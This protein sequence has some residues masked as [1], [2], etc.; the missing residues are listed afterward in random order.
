MD[1]SLWGREWLGSQTEV[2]TLDVK[3]A[4]LTAQSILHDYQD[5]FKGLGHIGTSSFVVDPSATPVQHTSRCIP[6]ALKKEVKAKL[7]D[8]ERRGI[9]VKETAP[10]EWISNM[11]VVAKPKKIRICLD[12]QELN[13]V[14][15][16]LKYQM[17]TL[18]ELLPKLCKAKIFSTP[19]AKDSFYQISLDEPSSKLTALWTPFGRYRYLQM[20]FSVSLTPEEFE[21]NLQEKLADLEGVEVIQDDIIVMGFG[22][23]QE[24]AVLNHDENLIKLLERARKVNLR[25]NSLKM[26][27]RKPEVKFMQHVISK[28]GLKPDPAKVK[29]VEDMPQ[30]SC[31]QE[32]LSLLGFVN[33]LSRFLLRLADVAQPLRD[34]TCKDAKFTW[35]KQHDTAFKEVKKLVV[36][37]PILKYY[38]CNAEV[39]LQ[40]DASERGLGAVILQ[41]G[42]LVAFAS[43]TLSP[44]ERRYA[45]IEKECLPIV[46]ACQR[47][48]QYISR[49]EKIKVESDHKPLQAIFKKSV[50]ASHPMQIAKDVTPPTSVQ[51]GCYIQTRF[52][53]VHSRPSFKSLPRQPRKGRQRVS[54]VCNE[55]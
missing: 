15:Q 40:W 6:I 23:T 36:N 14:I 31:K 33:Y 55:S 47:F 41:N 2:L 7:E 35:A 18:D 1:R 51:S 42:Q 30:P 48:S 54:S 38:D 26:E 22:E 3:Q 46:F 29:A 17:P 53:D 25:L 13:K 52:A 4:P 27:Q 50:L 10:T 20:P 21:S 9:I 43:E 24:Q 49:Q 19:D 5:V 8:L 12:P 16:H 11:V 32:V 39:T 28:E 34:L 45:Q 44:T 37:H